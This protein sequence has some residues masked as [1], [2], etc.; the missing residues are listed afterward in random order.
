MAMVRILN[1]P[2]IKHKNMTVCIQYTETK[3]VQRILRMQ[4]E[5]VAGIVGCKTVRTVKSYTDRHI[6]PVVLYK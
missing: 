1:K 2:C 6:K 4:A 5:C 3:I